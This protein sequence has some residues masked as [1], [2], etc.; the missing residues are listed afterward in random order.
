MTVRKRRRK[1]RNLWLNPSYQGRYIGLLMLCSVIVM[2]CYSSIFYLFVRDNFQMLMELAPASGEVRD[3]IQKDW[4]QTIQILFV[5][6]FL[7]LIST[8][9]IGLVF[10]HK[11]AGPLF[12][13]RQ[14]CERINRG[15]KDLRI[16]LRPG[17]HFKDLVEYL[18]YTFDRFQKPN[19]R[20]FKILR[21]RKH[22]NEIIE[23]E[24]LKHLVA[25]GVFTAKD[26]AI[27]FEKEGATPASI[28]KLFKESFDKT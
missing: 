24:K 7:F 20:Y 26:V 1:F 12:K 5:L 14:V 15:E 6:S 4:D 18:N 8:F 19:G 11:V 3:L 13:I 22:A 21:S 27:E 9:M 23:V 16:H 2:F 25:A 28:E 10:S 17:D